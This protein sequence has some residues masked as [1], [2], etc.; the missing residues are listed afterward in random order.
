MRK[1]T[2]ALKDKSNNNDES[3]EVED[4]SE[5]SYDRAALIDAF[6]TRRD[7]IVLIDNRAIK[8]RTAVGTDSITNT[9]EYTIADVIQLRYTSSKEM[10]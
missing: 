3:E 1:W 8:A 4:K 9:V 7:A 2:A 10:I 5:L 6:V